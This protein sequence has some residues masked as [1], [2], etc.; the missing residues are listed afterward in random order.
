[1]PHEETGIPGEV[2]AHRDAKIP[3]KQMP[4]IRQSLRANLL[5]EERL[6]GLFASWRL[7]RAIGVLVVTDRRLLTLGEQDKGMPVVDE[8]YRSTLV[9]LHVEREKLLSSGRLVAE[10]E[11]GMVGLG[12]LDYA[13]DGST[14]L[15]L[16]DVMARTMGA[17]GMPVIPVPGQEGPAQRRPGVSAPSDGPV[18]GPPVQGSAPGTHPLVAHLQSLADL[19]ERGALTDAEFAAAKA[20]LL[21]N[22][23]G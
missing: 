19:H 17:S 13:T 10:T 23:E 3:E 2:T 8:V 6:L 18:D 12:R 21:S 4:T 1:M 14:F 11:N 5:P 7:R 9:K 15:A 16:D 20:R 22:P